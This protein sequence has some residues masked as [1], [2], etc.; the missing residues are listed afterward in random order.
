MHAIARVSPSFFF[1]GLQEMRVRPFTHKRRYFSRTQ[2][3]KNEWMISRSFSRALK[4]TQKK[5]PS[6]NWKMSKKNA[7]KN[8]TRKKSETHIHKQKIHP[9]EKKQTNDRELIGNRTRVLWT[10]PKIQRKNE[11]QWRSSS[12]C[13]GDECS[14]GEYSWEHVGFSC[15]FVLF[16]LFFQRGRG[17]KEKTTHETFNRQVMI[18]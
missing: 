13:S 2:T 9:N 12:L 1:N 18:S 14:G 17:K 11:Y 16:L 10:I 6:P 15:K 3:N 8:T 5:V 7:Q 4:A